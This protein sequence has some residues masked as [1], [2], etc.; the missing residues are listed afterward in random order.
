MGWELDIFGKYQRLLEAVR[1]DAQAMSELRS[2]VVITVIADVARSYADI[3]G[4][5]L[6][7]KIAQKAVDAAQK[8]VTLTQTRFE[9][10]LTNELDATLAK[11]ELANLQAVLPQL[12][13]AIAL[14]ESRV[15]CCSASIA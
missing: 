3:R 7:L 14:A 4:L 10:G 12:R 2:A 8:N 9:R 15:S 11:R 6:R 13:A 5:Q 1:D